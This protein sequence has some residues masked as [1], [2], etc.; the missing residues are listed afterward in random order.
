MLFNQDPILNKSH[1][2]CYA[3]Y[4]LEK[5]TLKTRLYL[6]FTFNCRYYSQAYLNFPY[7]WINDLGILDQVIGQKCKEREF[8]YT[9]A[10]SLN[11]HNYF[12]ELFNKSYQK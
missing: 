9:V 6:N 2:K 1:Q 4:W 12:I 5:V 8:S 3:K 10:E 7:R 11:W